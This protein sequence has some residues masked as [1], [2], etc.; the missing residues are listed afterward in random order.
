MNSR[1][2]INIAIIAPSTFAQ[3]LFPDATF[4]FNT[5]SNLG[6]LYMEIDPTE[7]PIGTKKVTDE[8]SNQNNLIANLTT[9]SQIRSIGIAPFIYK[10]V[11]R[12]QKLIDFN[13][14]NCYINKNI[15]LNFYMMNTYTDFAQEINNA[16]IICVDSPDVSLLEN[17]LDIIK[18][19]AGKKY[20]IVA[21]CS[22]PMETHKWVST[23]KSPYSMD[24][25]PQ[26]KTE[27][28]RILNKSS[29]S[30]V[31]DNFESEVKS[32]SLDEIKQVFVKA[33]RLK[34]I[35]KKDYQGIIDNHVKSVINTCATFSSLDNLIEIYADNVPMLQTIYGVREKLCMDT[36]ENVSCV[37]YGE[38]L[39]TS[40][41]LPSEVNGL[42]EKIY[43]NVLSQVTD[44]GE[45]YR[46][47]LTAMGT[48]ICEL[49][50]VKA[51]SLLGVNIYL[52]YHAYFEEP[53]TDTMCKMLLKAQSLV[54][55]DTYQKCL[56]QIL[57]TKL[58]VASE[59]LDRSVDME[60]NN[61]IWS[62]CKSLSFYLGNINKCKFDYVFSNVS[63]CC[64]RLLMKSALDEQLAYMGANIEKFIGYETEHILTLEKFIVRQLLKRNYQSFNATDVVTD[65]SDG[66]FDGLDDYG[67]LDE[68][69]QRDINRRML[70]EVEEI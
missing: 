15:L 38:K 67:L 60:H 49:Y 29:R 6:T 20:L 1:I 18:V 42:F 34:K 5:A 21:N 2:S 16:N 13:S 47:H 54:D 23:I 8:C 50:G 28:V 48:H 4:T 22:T 31:E 35:F 52:L 55:F 37:L 43:D 12:V 64:T 41:F 40:I 66:E 45:Y 24:T 9:V 36:M 33:K 10:P 62:F 56:V 30:M 59:Y 25:L 65:G 63:D 14:A 70:E 26:F 39:T 17:L 11:N 69:Y 32:I 44:N 19:A 57:V 3:L 46:V 68:E 27:L 51:R 58:M 53:Q 7:F 61:K